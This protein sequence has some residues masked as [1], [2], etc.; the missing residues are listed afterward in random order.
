MYQEDF[1]YEE[2]F[3]LYGLFALSRAKCANC[4]QPMLEQCHRLVGGF[5]MVDAATLGLEQ[6][7]VNIY[8]NSGLQQG[9]LNVSKTLYSDLG[10]LLYEI[11]IICTRVIPMLPR[12]ILTLFSKHTFKNE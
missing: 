7:N 11:W 9:P 4:K 6:S 5:A 10:S 12:A 8:Y 3:A 2:T 1:E